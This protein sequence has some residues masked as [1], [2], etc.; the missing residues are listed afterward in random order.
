MQEVQRPVV[1]FGVEDRGEALARADVQVEELVP[2]N[3]RRPFLFVVGVELSM[4]FLQLFRE[5]CGLRR[6][7]CSVVAESA[8]VTG[9]RKVLAW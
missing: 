5:L 9:A 6:S 2:T 7:S 1:E 3:I 4:Q 8:A